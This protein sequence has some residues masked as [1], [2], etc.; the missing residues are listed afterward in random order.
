MTSLCDKIAD[1]KCCVVDIAGIYVDMVTYGN[2]TPDMFIELQLLNGYVRT[3]ERYNQEGKK[4]VNDSRV[5]TINGMALTND[6]QQL[7][8]KECYSKDVVNCISEISVCFI[9]EQIELV[10]ETCKCGC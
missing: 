4:K 7:L 6:G 5:L 1:A 2:D 8:T 10:C 9:L 3:L